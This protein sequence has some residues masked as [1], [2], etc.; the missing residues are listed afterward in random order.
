MDYSQKLSERQ[1]NLPDK[2][3]NWRREA[4]GKRHIPMI[5]SRRDHIQRKLLEHLDGIHTVFDGERK[6]TL[7][8]PPGKARLPG[9]SL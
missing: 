2:E 5:L 9:D 3:G 7:F 6:R 1:W 8:H 4:A